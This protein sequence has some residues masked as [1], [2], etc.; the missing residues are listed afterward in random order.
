M[1]AVP[2]EAIESPSR[3]AVLAR[4]RG[5]ARQLGGDEVALPI[6]A[7]G[8]L[9]PEALQRDHLAYISDPDC[10]AD[11]ARYGVLIDGFQRFIEDAPEGV[12]VVVL[13][14]GGTPQILQRHGEPCLPAVDMVAE[15][16]HSG[17]ALVDVRPRPAAEI[18]SG[19]NVPPLPRH[20]APANDNRRRD[21]MPARPK[22]ELVPSG[23]FVRG[24]VPPDYLVDGIMQSGFLYSLTGQT[25][26]G[27]TAVALL[28]AA[29]TALGHEFAGREVQRGRV[30]Y[31]AGEN[32]DDVAM[33]WIGLCHALELD[34]EAVDVHFVRGVFSVADFLAHIE[35]EAARLGGVG[36]IIVD[37]TA[38]FFTGTDENS[39]VEMG[40]YARQL[41]QLAQL[42]W[43]PAV[44]AASH[45]VKNAAA[46]SLLPRGGGAFLNEV[47][48]N[49]SLAKRGDT[50][51]LHW[52]GKHRGPDFPPLSFD[53][54]TVTAPGLVDSRGRAIPTVLAVPVQEQE[55]QQRATAASRDDELMLLA[56][57]ENGNRSLR[58][59]AESL[60]WEDDDGEP[61]K[62][63]AQNSTDRL[64][65]A[66]MAVYELQSW[67]LTRKGEATAVEAAGR[68][69]QREAKT[70]GFRKMAEGTRRSRARTRSRTATGTDGT[71]D[72]ID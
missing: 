71:A 24:F 11:P 37:T 40:A 29:A 38:A 43:R 28:L 31:F 44:V 67:K 25:G 34:A 22:P 32:P 15:A 50:S 42:P 66:G 1:T 9:D 21:R 8:N 60:G 56:I 19:F 27:K 14:G 59:L 7:A 57:R 51:V 35:S 13:D 58:D 17:A 55:V 30:F 16:I 63:R 18:W 65:R 33:R 47:D 61:S 23:D 46:D 5:M 49:L 48:G 6:D 36:L 69:F 53:M 10:P 3:D 20:P 39:N 41:R 12:S 62:K 26:S 45:P 68:V 70:E 64:K 2:A 4:V 72:E 54:R 52:Q